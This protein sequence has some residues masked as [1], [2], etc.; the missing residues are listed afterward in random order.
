[1]VSDSP[2]GVK[3]PASACEVSDRERIKRELARVALGE[4][5]LS[6]RVLASR[7]TAL[8]TL[9]RVTRD[10]EVHERAD[11]VQEC[12]DYPVDPA[13]RFDATCDP[14]WWP[15][16]LNWMWEAGDEREA[17]AIER[18]RPSVQR[19][20]WEAAGT[21]WSRAGWE[22]DSTPWTRALAELEP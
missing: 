1:V 9:E 4:V 13:G 17:T 11:R 12:V 6:G 7:V 18:W 10:E 3:L 22:V 20:R 8:R 2:A 14:A 5:E 21:P 16:R 19:V 15:L